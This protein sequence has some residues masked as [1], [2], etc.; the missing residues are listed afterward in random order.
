MGKRKIRMHS[1]KRSRSIGKTKA[2][3]K[4]QVS[5]I[6]LKRTTHGN[7]GYQIHRKHKHSKRH[8][9]KKRRYTRKKRGGSSYGSESTNVGMNLNTPTPSYSTPSNVPSSVMTPVLGNTPVSG[10]DSNSM[11]NET[12]KESI[13]NSKLNDM[14]GR[15]ATSLEDMNKTIKSY[16]NIN[17]KPEK[18]EKNEKE[19]NKGIL[20]SLFG[21]SEN[22]KEDEG[23][24]VK[25]DEGDEKEDEGDDDKP[26]GEDEKEDEN[27]D[28]KPDENEVVKPD[29]EDEGDKVDIDGEGDE[30]EDEGDGEKNTK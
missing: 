12:E 6:K 3:V 9:G 29:G 11:M 27:E 23:D 20:D 15:I 24:D 18:D 26:D 28:V 19:G 14:I 5:K 21:N 10:V 1:K 22:E 13:G 4:R 8:R 16:I 2:R 30:G 25:P 7:K 17:P